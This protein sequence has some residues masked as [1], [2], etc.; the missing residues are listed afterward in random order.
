MCVCRAML[1]LPLCYING[2]AIQKE[3]VASVRTTW[4][5]SWSKVYFAG[6]LRIKTHSEILTQLRGNEWKNPQNWHPQY[7]TSVLA[8]KRTILRQRQIYNVLNFT[9][10]LRFSFE[11]ERANVKKRFFLWTLV[12]FA[13][14]AARITFRFLMFANTTWMM[15]YSV[16]YPIW[17]V[18]SPRFCSLPYICS[19]WLCFVCQQIL[20]II[21]SEIE[22]NNNTLVVPSIKSRF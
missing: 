4:R 11:F 1:G 5:Y 9:A 19:R 7:P 18:C 21:I 2:A 8:L 12:R 13:A 22:H 17:F 10:I 15:N 14:H 3:I 6:F 16:W 20:S